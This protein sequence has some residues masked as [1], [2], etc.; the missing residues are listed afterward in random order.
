MTKNIFISAKLKT[1]V[2]KDKIISL[3][4]KL[5]NNI[6][7]AYSIQYQD[8]ASEVKEIL[9]NKNITQ[10]VQV[11]GCSNPAFAKGTEA[12]LIITDGKFHAVSLA[13]ESGLPVYVLYNNNLEKISEKN[14]EELRRKKKIAH[15]KFLHS[16][17][18]GVLVTTKPGQQLLSRA[19]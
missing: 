18:V 5:P 15:L 10:V 19:I 12:I 1:K 13:L 11:L 6:A 7:I 3:S 9:K 8:I 2:N 16:D 17:R 14:I 4:E